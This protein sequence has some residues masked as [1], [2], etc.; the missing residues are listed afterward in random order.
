MQKG[1][2]KSSWR[3]EELTDLS[4]QLWGRRETGITALPVRAGLR[5]SQ[6]LTDPIKKATDREV[7]G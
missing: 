6:P 1:L 4:L 2:R 5:R 3:K 7:L